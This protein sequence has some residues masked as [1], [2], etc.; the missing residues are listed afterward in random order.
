[1]Q[2]SW[3]F[4][5]RSAGRTLQE[6]RAMRQLCR[7]SLA[8][9]KEAVFTDI[10]FYR[11]DAGDSRD[12]ST[13]RPSRYNSASTSGAQIGATALIGRSPSNAWG[14]RH[15]FPLKFA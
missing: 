10:A 8:S 15:R 5:V 4:E 3:V 1:M 12:R 11:K 6:S 14:T 13:G 2:A 7:A 9:G